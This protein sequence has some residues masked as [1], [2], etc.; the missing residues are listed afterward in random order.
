MKKNYYQNLEKELLK[1]PKKLELALIDDIDKFLEKASKTI[2]AADKSLIKA[3]NDLLGATVH[4]NTAKMKALDALK[5][6]K[7]LGIKE[8]IK[9]FSNR[10]DECKYYTDITEAAYTKVKSGINELP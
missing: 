1:Q 6:A 3:N 10:I 7:E 4:I 8:A 5:M 2:S 9:L